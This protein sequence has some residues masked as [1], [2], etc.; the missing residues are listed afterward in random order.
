MRLIRLASRAVIGAFDRTSDVENLLVDL[1]RLGVRGLDVSV[2]G[3]VEVVATLTVPER[4][5]GILG[6]LGKKGNWLGELK[7]LD[8][9]SVGKLTASGPLGEILASSPSTSPT[10]ALVMQGIPQ[11]DALIY[12]DLLKA[13]KVL[14]LVGVA[15]RTVGERI[16]AAFDHHSAQS[17]SYY[18]GRPY[19]T[20]YHGVGPGLQ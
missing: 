9:G 17:I 19:G 6:A 10:G 20:A 2:V 11:R 4:R 1:Q 14:V 7:T 5:R 12:S 15:D 16:R 8:E 3:K 18:A 13:G